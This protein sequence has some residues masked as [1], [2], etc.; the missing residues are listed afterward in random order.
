MQIPIPQKTR[1]NWAKS[2]AIFR[3]AGWG[4]D[5]ITKWRTFCEKHELDR[6]NTP[7][8][9]QTSPEIAGIIGV[10]KTENSGTTSTRFTH[11]DGFVCLKID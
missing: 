7:K 4:E 10:E 8:P 6:L 5:Q 11:S 9:Q 1:D 3:S 2:D